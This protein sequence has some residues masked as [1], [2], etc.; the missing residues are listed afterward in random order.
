M[1][2]LAYLAVLALVLVGSGWLEVLLGVRVWR[3]P[4]RLALTLLP[5]VAVFYAWDVY[6]IAHGQWSFDPRRVLGVR[7][8]GHVP[9]EELAFFVVVPVAA[10]LTLEAVRKVRGW[11]VGD[12]DDGRPR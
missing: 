6:A 2:H 3:R 10:L 9:V 5:V 12:E 8:P 4:R 1:S 7:L 11:P